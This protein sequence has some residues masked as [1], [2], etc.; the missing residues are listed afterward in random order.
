MGHMAENSNQLASSTNPW[1]IL[2]SFSAA[3]MEISWLVL[4]YQGMGPATASD[5]TW[6][7]FSFFLAG[8]VLAGAT[9]RVMNTLDLNKTVERGI[10]AVFLI[11]SYLIG[12]NILLQSAEQTEFDV[13]ATTLRGIGELTAL[14]PGEVWLAIALAWL[15]WRGF[16]F[17][18]QGVGRFAVMGF[19]RLGIG[20]FLVHGVFSLSGNRELPGVGMFGIFLFAT[21]MALTASRVSFLGRIRGGRRNPFTRQWFGSIT[22]AVFGTVG[23]GFSVALLVVGRLQVFLQF[24]LGLI[25]ALV[26]APLL[27]FVGLFTGTDVSE[28]VPPTPTPGIALPPWEQEAG[29]TPNIVDGTARQVEALPVNVRSFVFF[30]GFV[31]CVILFFVMVW[32]LS[33]G[34]RRLARNPNVEYVVKRGDLIELLR[35][36]AGEQLRQPGDWLAGR[37]QGR[38]RVQAAARVRQIYGDLLDLCADLDI[39]RPDSQTPLEFLET[40]RHALPSARDQLDSITHAYLKVRYGELPETREEVLAVENAWEEVHRVGEARKQIVRTQKRAEAQTHKRKEK[41]A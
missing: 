35:K 37:L 23:T 28:I 11:L 38:Q 41:T 25:I 34:Y 16:T 26:F 22:G 31:L 8:M 33:K 6:L 2:A 24:L 39:P 12:S 32:G 15:L 7:P 27:F 1:E 13:F 18:R 19:L 4:L 20:M 9:A 14:I 10:S 36:E 30:A 29:Y 5:P 3:V 17:V 40:V 21:L